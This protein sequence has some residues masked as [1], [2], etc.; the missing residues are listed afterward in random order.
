MSTRGDEIILLGMESHYNGVRKEFSELTP[1]SR[2]NYSIILLQY[3]KIK[4]LTN[5]G[6]TG[7]KCSVDLFSPFRIEIYGDTKY[8]F[9]L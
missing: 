7:E 2:S 1:L 4:K 9:A 8:N 6:F 3:I 5:I